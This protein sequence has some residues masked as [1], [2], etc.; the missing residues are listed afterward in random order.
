MAVP[1]AQLSG[2]LYFRPVQNV[3]GRSIGALGK[4]VMFP[5]LIYTNSVDNSSA[6]RLPFLKSSRG[7]LGD[8]LSRGV[9]ER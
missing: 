4:P 5:G 8:P 3:D 7:G 9:A 2:L 6:F 1:E